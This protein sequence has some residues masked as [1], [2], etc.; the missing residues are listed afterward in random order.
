M[1]QKSSIKG[2]T[3]TI[4]GLVVKGQ[5][6]GRLLGFPTANLDRRSYSRRKQ[7]IKLGIYAGTAE[8]GNQKLE[9]RNYPAGIIIGPIDKEGLPK[10]EAHLIGFKGNL[11]GKKITVTLQK[12][13]RPFKKFKSEV[14]LKKQIKFDI[15]RV[16][17]LES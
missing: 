10:L 6:Y 12:F 2:K 14:E 15:Q 11:Y 3:V 9:I 4:S 8:I 17:E 16:R 5:Q 13:L 7:N 1:I